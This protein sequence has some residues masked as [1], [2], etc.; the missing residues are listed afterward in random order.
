[1]KSQVPVSA[2]AVRRVVPGKRKANRIDEL[3]Q[4]NRSKVRPGWHSI[5][6]RRVV[7][8]LLGRRPLSLLAHTAGLLIQDKSL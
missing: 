6:I 7:S 3:R 8:G 5:P 2:P 1:M 4:T